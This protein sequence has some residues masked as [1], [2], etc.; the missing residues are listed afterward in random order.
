MRVGATVG[1]IEL[2]GCITV[3]RDHVVVHGARETVLPVCWVSYV[4]VDGVECA[5]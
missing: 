2:A 1:G 5:A 3:G 4:V